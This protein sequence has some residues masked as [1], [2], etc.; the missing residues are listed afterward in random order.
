MVFCLE[1]EIM[2]SPFFCRK[3][4]GSTL[5]I[6][7]KLDTVYLMYIYVSFGMSCLHEQ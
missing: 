6:M 5:R 7:S 4:R 2:G 1:W 3:R